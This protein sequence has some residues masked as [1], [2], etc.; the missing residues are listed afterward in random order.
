MKL[1]DEIEILREKI[2][3]IDKL[4]NQQCCLQSRLG[5]IHLIE[6]AFWARNILEIINCF[7]FNKYG[8]SLKRTICTICPVPDPNYPGR[9]KAVYERNKHISFKK[10]L[11]T[12]VHFRYLE[13]NLYA[14]GRNCLYVKNCLLYTSPSPR[15]RTRSRMPSSA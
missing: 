11:G 10:L 5:Y 8:H 3:Q 2:H 4:P 1:I 15:D 12:M 6:A 14:D 13:L 9:D 7:D